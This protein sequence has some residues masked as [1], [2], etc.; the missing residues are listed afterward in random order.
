MTT[1]EFSTAY[2]EGF[3]RTQ[4]FL[5]WLGLGFPRAEEVAQ[6]AWSKAWE[7]RAQLRDE[8]SIGAWVRV[9]ALNL[10]RNEMRRTRDCVGLGDPAGPTP[11]AIEQHMDA[12]KVL[13]TLN[14]EDR[15]LMLLH[16]VGG[17]TSKEIAA[18][19][20]LSPVGVRVRLHRVTAKLRRRFW[21]YGAAE[22]IWAS[23][24]SSEPRRHADL[25]R[26]DSS[27]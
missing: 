24:A 10:L 21:D 19:S 27:F 1:E 4:F 5:R 14:P 12:N 15:R 16:V 8:N 13:E 22:T 6:A 18:K 17:F 3:H 11:C 9:I 23:Y 20:G 7:R 2:N 26:M 25:G